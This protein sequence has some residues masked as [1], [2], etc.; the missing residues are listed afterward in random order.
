ME[1]LFDFMRRK[2]AQTMFML[3]GRLGD[4][5]LDGIFAGE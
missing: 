1:T 4:G 2:C 5:L 3:H